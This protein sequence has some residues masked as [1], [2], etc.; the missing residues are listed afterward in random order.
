M[1]KGAAIR[2][3]SV[4]IAALLF[5][6]VAA[7]GPIYACGYHG[8]FSARVGA[9]LVTTYWPID[10][11]CNHSSVLMGMREWYVNLFIEPTR[12]AGSRINE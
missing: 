9:A 10:F 3:V 4:I 11:L 12:P 8:R 1:T 2:Q 5:A 6:Y 7:I